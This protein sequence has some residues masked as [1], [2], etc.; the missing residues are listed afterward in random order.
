MLWRA[1]TSYTYIEFDGRIGPQPNSRN[2]MHV[3]TNLLPCPCIVIPQRSAVYDIVRHR[4]PPGYRSVGIPPPVTT[5]AQTEYQPT[6]EPA[7]Y[8]Y[9]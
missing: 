1:L 2:F 9:R 4:V 7:P 8:R 3:A 6:P 5:V